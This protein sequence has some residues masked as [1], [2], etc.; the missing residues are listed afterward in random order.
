MES[1]S[2][3]SARFIHLT[4]QPGFPTEDVSPENAEVLGHLIEDNP[5][6]LG[7]ANYLQGHQRTVH[8]MAVNALKK[9]GTG[10]EDSFVSYKSFTYGFAATEM[11]MMLL[12]GRAFDTVLAARRVQDLFPS[13]PFP[14]EQYLTDLFPSELFPPSA[15]ALQS[16]SREIS[17]VQ[18]HDSWPD[19]QPH[20]FG[21]MLRLTERSQGDVRAVKAGILGSQ[22]ATE[23]QSPALAA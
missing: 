10:G 1:E 2:Q 16:I 21:L 3:S 9:F 14:S 5:T 8:F 7:Q 13:N 15:V 20:M 17:L 18:R 12:R 23:L 22:I 6:V 4:L 19:R 11:I